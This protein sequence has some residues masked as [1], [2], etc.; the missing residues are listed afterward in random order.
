MR[1][2]DWSSDVCSSDLPYSPEAYYIGYY[3]DGSLPLPGNYM[4]YHPFQ[5]DHLTVRDENL[6]GWPRQ[7]EL[8]RKILSDY[9]A[10][11][12]HLVEQIDRKGDVE[13]KS[14]SVSVDHGGRTSNKNQKPPEIQNNRIDIK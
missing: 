4:P 2:S 6:T 12:T 3:P 10:L 9:Y 13:G 7:P 1:I 5:F 11:I 8:I 14:V